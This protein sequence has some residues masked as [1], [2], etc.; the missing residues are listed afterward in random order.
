L[1][2]ADFVWVR[3]KPWKEWNPKNPPSFL[4]TAKKGSDD[5]GDVYLE[6][7]ELVFLTHVN[8]VPLVNPFPSSVPLF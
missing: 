6:P 1:S 8:V 3:S 5:K 7:E 4:L 2:F